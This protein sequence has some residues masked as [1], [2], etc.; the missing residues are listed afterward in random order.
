[1]VKRLE[2]DKQESVETLKQLHVQN[3]QIRQQMARLA[4]EIKTNQETMQAKYIS[5][6]QES[7]KQ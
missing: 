4:L 1:M 5:S 7:E 3:E 2:T 6:K